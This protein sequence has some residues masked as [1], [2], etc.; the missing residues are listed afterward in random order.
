VRVVERQR[1]AE[2][3]ALDVLDEWMARVE[4]RS[5]VK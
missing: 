4:A 3:L 5:G 2:V 1:Q